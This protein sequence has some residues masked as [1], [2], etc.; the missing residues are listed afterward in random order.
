MAMDHDSPY[1]GSAVRYQD[2]LRKRSRLDTP[3]STRV[4]EG[5]ARTDAPRKTHPSRLNDEFM[6]AEVKA[7]ADD[8]VKMAYEIEADGETCPLADVY[9]AT[10]TAEGFTRDHIPEFA[11]HVDVV[12]M[13]Q[14][15][16]IRGQ[17]VEENTACVSGDDAKSLAGPGAVD[18]AKVRIWTR[19]LTKY[20]REISI[21]CSALG[22]ESSRYRHWAVEYRG[23]WYDLHKDPEDGSIHRRRISVKTQK[24]FN[25]GQTVGTSTLSLRA[26]SQLAHC[27][28]AQRREKGGKFNILRINCQHYARDLAGQTIFRSEAVGLRVSLTKFTKRTIETPV[29]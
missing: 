11:E 9:F 25:K 4:S 23:V 22:C 29:P 16:E 8:L 20:G 2:S 26:W 14:V 6:S 10:S 28:M 17:G 7:L 19:R 24:S 27:R 15:D 1:L 18:K 5:R 13:S 21:A 12:D 3:G